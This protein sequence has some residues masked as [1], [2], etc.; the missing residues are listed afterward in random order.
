MC[1]VHVLLLCLILSYRDL[2]LKVQL[3]SQKLCAMN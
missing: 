3:V 2:R 1:V